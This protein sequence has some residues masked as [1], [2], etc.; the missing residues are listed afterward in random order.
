MPSSPSSPLRRRPNRLHLALGFVVALILAFARF[1]GD[2]AG[3]LV[4][5]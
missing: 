1:S 4:F 2:F 5:F 3:G